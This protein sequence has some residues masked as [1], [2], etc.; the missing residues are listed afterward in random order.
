[1]TIKYETWVPVH[2]ERIVESGMLDSTYER[3]PGESSPTFTWNDLGDDVLIVSVGDDY[4]IVS[5]LTGG[6]WYYLQGSEC[7]EEAEV[8][9]AGQTTTMPRSVILERGQGLEVLKHAG[10]FMYLLKAYSWVEQ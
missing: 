1:M 7:T 4:S 8:N 5:M 2:Q 3:A 6:T 9:M 10:D